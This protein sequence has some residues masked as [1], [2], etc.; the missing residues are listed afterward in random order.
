MAFRPFGE[1]SS[2]I[3]GSVFVFDTPHR[4]RRLLVCLTHRLHVGVEFV[5][6]HVC[7]FSDMPYC[8]FRFWNFRSRSMVCSMEVYQ[9]LKDNI[10]QFKFPA[11]VGVQR[12]GAAS[13]DLTDF[14]GQKRDLRTMEPVAGEIGHCFV[15]GAGPGNLKCTIWSY[16]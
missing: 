16:T 7:F 1:V 9:E 8:G 12:L 13:I 2:V 15:V 3:R 5:T 4:R 6:G 10:L 11:R 14:A